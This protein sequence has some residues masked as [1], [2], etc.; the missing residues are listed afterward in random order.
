MFA[1]RS[2]SSSKAKTASKLT[3]GVSDVVK[4]AAISDLPQSAKV[5]AVVVTYN[6]EFGALRQI[7]DAL[8]AQGCSV[9]MVDNASAEQEALRETYGQY[10]QANH[11]DLQLIFNTQNLGLGAAHNQ[12]L[13]AA[14]EGGFDYLLIMDQDSLPAAAMVE[15]LVSAHQRLSQTQN[16][17][18]VGACYLNA[19]NQSESFFVRFGALK[20]QREYAVRE[21]INADFLISSGSLF[22]L[23]ALDDIGGMDEELFIDHV[24]TEWFLRARSRGYSAFGVS[25]ARMQ[26]SLGED[27]HAITLGGRQRNV[28]QHKPFRYYYIFRN[29]LNLY[30]RGYTSWLWKWN[31]V[32]RLAMIFVMFGL[33]K[34][35]R[36]ANL[37]MMLLGAWHGLLGRSGQTDFGS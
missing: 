8:S 19:Q 28:P 16:V 5:L 18:A 12:G 36:L 35:P 25:A 29:S 17:S 27:T 21:F 26:H 2:E 31:D 32:Q 23:S 9:L 11:T 1:A 22:S 4:Q 10:T 20:F 14:Q 37:K 30:R 34:S 6:P 24:D 13:Q 3:T 7:V 15:H 33:L